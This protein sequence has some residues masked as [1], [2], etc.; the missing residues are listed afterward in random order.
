MEPHDPEIEKTPN[1]SDVRS[2]TRRVLQRCES[3]FGLE[4]AQRKCWRR[5]AYYTMRQPQSS[6][7]P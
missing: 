7:F 4:E 6:S 5:F 2:K 1:F 3:E